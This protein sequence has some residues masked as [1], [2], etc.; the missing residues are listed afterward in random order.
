MTKARPKVGDDL[1]VQRERA[2]LVEVQV[3]ATAARRE[4]ERLSHQLADDDPNARKSATTAAAE[5]LLAGGE[6]ATLADP[7]RLTGELREAHATRR[8]AAAAVASPR[9]RVAEVENRAARR[10]LEGERARAREIAEGVGAALLGLADA[11]AEWKIWYS[12]LEA[13][14]CSPGTLFQAMPTALQSMAPGSGRFEA[15]VGWLAEAGGLTQAE[16]DRALA[17]REVAA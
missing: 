11:V 16:A 2:K 14:G 8:G 7:E 17:P 1:D 10:L 6:L 15:A 4:I 5:A 9:R 12:A 3:A 13:D